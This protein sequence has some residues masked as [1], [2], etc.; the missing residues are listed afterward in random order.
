MSLA[1]P[2]QHKIFEEFL[3]ALCGL[4]KK[5]ISSV[6]GNTIQ[7]GIPTPDNPIVPKNFL[8]FADSIS[9]EPVEVY[10]RHEIEAR[11]KWEQLDLHIG[12]PVWVVGNSRAWRVLRGYRR[13][14]DKY[15]VTFTDAN[16]EINFKDL[17]LYT[18]ETPKDSKEEATK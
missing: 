18:S 3:A 5:T 7:N 12:K 15:L 14:N 16:C 17:K 13:S 4:Q 10:T 9:S 2:E 6:S 11:I 1:T 8:M